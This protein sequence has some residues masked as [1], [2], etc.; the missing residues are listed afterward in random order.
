MNVIEMNRLISYDG[1]VGTTVLVVL[2]H[3]LLIRRGRWKALGL[4]HLAGAANSVIELFMLSRGIRL[5]QGSGWAQ[6]LAFLQISW[7]DAGWFVML[8]YMNTGFILELMQRFSRPHIGEAVMAPPLERRAGTLAYINLLFFV[9]MILAV[10]DY[11]LLDGAVLARRV[12]ARPRLVQTYQALSVAIPIVVMSFLGFRRLALLLVIQGA[13]YGSAFQLRL[14][15][16][17]IRQAS[18]AGGWDFALD[19]LTLASSIIMTLGLFSVLLGQLNMDR[20]G[21]R[22]RLTSASR[23]IRIRL[24]AL[25]AMGKSAISAGLWIPV[26]LSMILQ[27]I[28]GRPWRKLPR[29][30]NRKDRQSRALIGDAVLMY[31]QLLRRLPQQEALEAIRGIIYHSAMRFLSDSIP[32]MDPDFFSRPQGELRQRV[33]SMVDRF[34]NTDYVLDKVQYPRLRY[35]VTRCRFVELCHV[36]GHPELAAAFCAADGAFFKERQPLISMKR[37]Q[38]IASGD[39]ICDFDFTVTDRLTD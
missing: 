14:F 31:R 37:P 24:A 6:V 25:K 30:K 9:G 26:V 1:L 17:G 20:V 15:I 32:P 34:P 10:M 16:T 4:F 11:G 5:L 35:L 36:L 33:I 38:T 21:D 19:A 3:I 39:D 23:W 13:A 22:R 28:L 27:S 2:M 8:A 29:P 18:R 12:F 7:V